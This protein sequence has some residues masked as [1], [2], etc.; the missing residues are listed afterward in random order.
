MRLL[1]RHGFPFDR[2]AELSKRVFVRA[3]FEDFALSARKP[4]ASRASVLTG[5]TRK[6]VQRL[7]ALDEEPA[8]GTPDWYNRA[9]RVL[10]G[11]IR[12]PEFLD[13]DGQ[14]R[15]LKLGGEDGFVALVKRH[16]G[17]MPARA[18][19]DE[20]LRVG[21]VE[22]IADG[23]LVPIM[24]AYIPQQ[25]VAEKLA[26]LASDVADLITTIEHNIEHGITDARYQRKVMYHSMPVDA[27]PAF[28]ALSA[29]QAQAL[30]EQ[31]DQWLAAHDSDPPA[32]NP[33]VPRARLGI[34][35]YYFEERLVPESNRG[36]TP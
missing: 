24:R 6:D 12:D 21:A 34:G 16:S 7:V 27:I 28:N 32:D 22:R 13:A 15:P 29:R 36:P 2:F 1:L 35:I 19:F 4:T 18:V 14:P 5:L 26:I 17:D 9:A 30:L 20:L 8:A 31:L 23:R 25:G 33:D 11:W 10:T 3:A